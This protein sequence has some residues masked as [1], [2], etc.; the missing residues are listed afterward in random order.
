MG[1]VP[2]KRVL[3]IDHGERRI[4]LA[5]SD[6]RL[7]MAHP[8]KVLQSRSWKEDLAYLKAL[9]SD[10]EVGL[11]VVGLPRNMDGSEGPQAKI[12]K[13]F[14]T[15]LAAGLGLEVVTWDERLSSMEADSVLDEQGLRR[16]TRKGRQRRKAARDAIAASLILASFLE[17]R[18]ETL[19]AAGWGEGLPGSRAT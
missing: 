17:A 9:C 19:L 1:Q 8:G 2:V 5:W 10:R 3:G 4:G 13:E 18:R 7:I 15:K 12:V 11:V 16:S 6:P 14:A